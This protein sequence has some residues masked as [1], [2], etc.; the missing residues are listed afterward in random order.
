MNIE[1]TFSK[2][3]VTRVNGTRLTQEEEQM[4]FDKSSPK[5]KIKGH[6]ATQN[7][8]NALK[9]AIKMGTLTYFWLKFPNF[10]GEY[11]ART[12]DPLLVRQMLSQLS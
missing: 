4:L 10:G 7:G 11:R 8:Q 3:S 12:C 2:V 5:C 1:F 6:L 9:I